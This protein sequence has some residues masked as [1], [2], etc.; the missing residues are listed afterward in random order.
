MVATAAQVSDGQGLNWGGRRKGDQSPS[1][2]GEERGRH[3]GWGDIVQR[4]LGWSER[5]P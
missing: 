3:L 1:A 5:I 2:L 4:R